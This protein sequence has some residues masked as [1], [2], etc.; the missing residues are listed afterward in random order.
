MKS[1]K[2]TLSI[3][4]ASLLTILFIILKLTGAIT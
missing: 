4:W 3:P 2:V 1:T